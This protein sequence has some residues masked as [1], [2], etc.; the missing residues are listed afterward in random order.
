MIDKVFCKDLAEGVQVTA[1]N[2]FFVYAADNGFV[3]FGCH[4]M[5][6]SVSTMFC[7]SK[8]ETSQSQVHGINPTSYGIIAT[9][10]ETQQ[11]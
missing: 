3:L 8:N 10:R 9:S 11:G 7:G 5:G 2:E 6:F 1:F 4:V